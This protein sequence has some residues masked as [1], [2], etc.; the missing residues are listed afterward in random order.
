MT[1][2]SESAA[3]EQKS[4]TVD[5]CESR[6]NQ[7]AVIMGWGRGR[8]SEKQIAITSYTHNVC[9]RN[10][11]D[12][13]KTQYSVTSETAINLLKN[14]ASNNIRSKDMRWECKTRRKRS[15][16][17]K[18]KINWLYFYEIISEVKTVRRR[19]RLFWDSKYI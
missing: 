15:S 8:F 14:K 7:R 2:F 10:E 17:R 9:T 5:F 12:T 1:S 11:V 13:R 3:A 16:P 19:F 6:R 4:I 18:K